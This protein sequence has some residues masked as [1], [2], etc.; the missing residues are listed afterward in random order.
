MNDYNI[1]PTTRWDVT[2]QLK[3][4]CYCYSCWRSQSHL[5]VGLQKLLLLFMLAVS[6]P[7]VCWLAK[8]SQATSLFVTL[9]GEASRGVSLII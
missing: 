9:D 2:T 4:H 3:N 5:F 7:L 6:V 1:I 8:P